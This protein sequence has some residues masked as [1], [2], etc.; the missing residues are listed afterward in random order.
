MT[1]SSSTNRASYSGNGSTTVFAYGF[2]IFDQDDLTVIL[3]AA[4]G[5]ETTQTITTHYTVSGVGSVSGGNVTFGTA[6]ASGVTVV[7][8]R[9]QPLTQGLDLVANDPF[10]SASFE[11]QLDKL[12]FMI[13]QHDEELGRAIKASKT[14][15]ITGSEF[16]I[17]A[18]DRA[19]K[20]FAFDSS[21]DVNITQEIGTFK[22]N[23]AASTAYVVRDLVKDTSTNN[24]FI[25]NSAHTSSGSQPLTTNTN[26]TK[27]DLIVDAATAATSATAASTSATTAAASETNASTSETNAST[28]ETNASTSETNAATSATNAATSATNAATSETNAAS[29]ETAAASSA[30]TAST[31][32]TAASTSATAAATSAT[33]A[34][35]SQTAAAT[36]ATNASTSETNA[37]TSATNAATSATN[38]ATSETNAATSATNAASSATAAASSATSAAASYDSFDDRYLGSKSSAPS[39]DNDGDALTTGALYW[40]STNSALN[41]WDG[42][43]WTALSSVSLAEQE[44][45]ATNGQTVFSVTGGIA[46]ANNTSVY[47]NGAKLFSTDVT[48]SAAANTVTLATGATTG[49]LITVT[50]VAGSSSGGGGSGIALT[51]LSVTQ[52]S[53]SGSGSLTYNNTSGV[54]S[55][56]PPASSGA[57]TFTGLTDTPSSLGT[58]GQILQVASGGSA[59]EFTDASSGG[60]S[61]GKA[62][63]MAI[64]FGG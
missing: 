23:W 58:A 18:T 12:T 15:T 48:I 38:A 60:V 22:G 59:L 19:N 33:A 34:S 9:E 1:V 41:I 61:T 32:A 3:R 10:P 63:A 40:N 57:T 30:S 25:V 5:T 50:E 28:S 21:G 62:I 47:L 27:Y 29:S 37:S 8:L 24:I 64:V 7:I 51:D 13:Q 17:S 11:D 6:P 46:D 16:T 53:A 44:F 52:N 31:Q 45:T 35:N 2:K 4:D 43:A 55:Y 36:S 49:D 20:I 54:F 26:S 56:T 39:T 14:N 42:S